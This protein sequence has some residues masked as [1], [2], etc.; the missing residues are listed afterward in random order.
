MGKHGPYETQNTT[1]T[2]CMII[3]MYQWDVPFDIIIFV[4]NNSV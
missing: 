1:W 3:E 2:A 4:W